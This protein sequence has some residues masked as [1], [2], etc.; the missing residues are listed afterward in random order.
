MTKSNF[1]GDYKKARDK[2]WEVISNYNVSSLPVDVIGLC[3]GMGIITSSYQKAKRTI[4][5]FGLAEYASGNDG[6]ATVINGRY[7]IF[8]D[9]TVT[10]QGR[11]R[12]TLAHELGHIVLGH[13]TSENISCRAGVTVWN[14]SEHS[15]PNKLEA[16]ANI[17]SSRLL[18]PACVLW[19]LDLHAPEAIA[20]LCGLS[21]SAAKV[22][23]ERMEQLYQR[24]REWLRKYN[25][26]CFGIS[27]Q[28][29]AAL[30]Q[31]EKFINY[32]KK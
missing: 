14:R 28:E 13:L 21:A 12:F 29:K 2:A 19:A 20:E 1:Y 24:E 11:I 16:A 7:F 8:Y 18:A 17:F 26:T 30:K 23:S 15:E 22:R 32:K 4:R 27:A 10:P 6:F 5:A 31:F 3:A 9:D 25:K